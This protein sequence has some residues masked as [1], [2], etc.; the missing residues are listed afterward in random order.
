MI[1]K[2]FTFKEFN[3]IFWTFYRNRQLEIISEMENCYKEENYD[4]NEDFSN[5]IKRKRLREI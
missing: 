2:N 1:N 5:N 4:I 3:E